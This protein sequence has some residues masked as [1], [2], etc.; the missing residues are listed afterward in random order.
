MDYNSIIPQMMKKISSVHPSQIALPNITLETLLNFFPFGLI[1]NKEM[2]ISGAGTNLVEAW[3]AASGKENPNEF[4]GSPV[5]DC[6]KLRRPTGIQFVFET[7][8]EV[9]FQLVD[10]L[11]IH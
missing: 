9:Q 5:L 7:V 11:F 2:R 1:I 10:K 6:F 8:R 4:L 3:K